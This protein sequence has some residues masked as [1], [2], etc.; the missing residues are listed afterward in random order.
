MIF[1]NQEK[2]EREIVMFLPAWRKNGIGFLHEIS[3]LIIDH[4]ASLFN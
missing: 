2:T 1:P 3:V 4:E